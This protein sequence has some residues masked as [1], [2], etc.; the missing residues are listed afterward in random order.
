LI[1]LQDGTMHLSLDPEV[2]NIPLWKVGGRTPLHTAPWRD[3]IAVQADLNLPAV[4]KRLA[5]DFLCAPFGHDDVTHGP[6]H[7]PPANSP[8]DVVAQTTTSAELQLSVPLR[9][10]HVRKLVQINAAHSALYQTH[11]VTG[12]QGQ[13]TL[14][15]HP[16][17]HLGGKGRLS[18]SPKQAILTDVIAQYP[19]HALWSSGQMRQDMHLTCVDGQLWDCRDY[20]TDHKVEDFAIL[21]EAPDRKI[22]WT[23]VM[24]DDED[25]MLIILKDAAV[26]PLTMLWI[27]NG[28]RDFAPWNGRHTGVLGI[29]DGIAGGANG[30]AMALSDNRLTDL[31]VP[32][33]FELGATHRFRHAM[34]SLPRPKGW[35]DLAALDLAPGHLLLY[36]SNGEIFK[37]PFVSEFFE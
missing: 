1:N 14:A 22:G 18:F 10:A 35:Q 20:P 23:C 24:R 12:G 29:E 5:G 19:G 7:G 13:M 31:G 4:N 8:W 16:M 26:L 25:D 33:Y 37:H 21:V 17:T 2:G 36:A 9:G 3:D 32:T 27:S 34:I 15:H 28:G 6:P 11:T 30:F